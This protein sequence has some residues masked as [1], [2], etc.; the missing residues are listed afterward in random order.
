MRATTDYL[1]LNK[2]LGIDAMIDYS[3]KLMSEQLY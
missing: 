1:V 3:I 2:E